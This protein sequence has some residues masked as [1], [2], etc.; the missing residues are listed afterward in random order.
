MKILFFGDSNTAG[1]RTD[2]GY[3]EPSYPRIAAGELGAQTKIC[4]DAIPGRNAI[5]A[6]GR[7]HQDL[8]K[9]TPD[10]L[11]LMLG[12]NDCLFDPMRRTEDVAEA[13]DGMLR[14]AYEMLPGMKILLVN[15]PVIPRSQSFTQ[16]PSASIRSKKLHLALEK[17]ADAD[18]LTLLDADEIV[19]SFQSDRV[20]MD[21]EAHQALGKAIA[22]EI[23]QN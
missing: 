3:I 23:Q 4:V 1:F 10:V 14:D 11:V 20:H 13:I 15:P 21:E 18:Y 6:E 8:K 2:G 12:S 5:R 17:L 22:R 16:D 9:L 19:Q 7:L